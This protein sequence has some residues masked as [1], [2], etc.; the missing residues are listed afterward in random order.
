MREVFWI[1]ARQLTGKWRLLIMAALAAVPV[2]SAVIQR[3][4]DEGPVSASDIDSVL[5]NG[6]L[7]SAI[8]PLIVLGVATAAF[9]NEVEDRTLSN[10]TLT[11]VSRWR[12]VLPKLASAIAVAAPAPL[13]AG[14]ISLSLLLGGQDSSGASMVALGAGLFVGIAVYAAVFL[15]V[16]LLTTRALWFGLL[17]VFLWEGLF[18]QFVAGIRYVSIK[19]YVAGIIHAI[20]SERFADS[21]SLLSPPVAIGMSVAVF[22]LFT[23][24]SVRRLRTMDVP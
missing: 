13:A 15:W 10:L 5:I 8:M 19:Q 3:L 23:V 24:L 2:V 18:S 1:S 21:R 14:L 11:P 17:Y 7:T 22:V 9:A 4:S 12:I 16:G 20:D 6:L